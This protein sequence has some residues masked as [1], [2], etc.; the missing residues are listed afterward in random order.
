[1]TLAEENR[2]LREKIDK[3]EEVLDK[4]MEGPFFS[5]AISSKKHDEM[6]RVTLEDGKEVFL[7]VNPRLVPNTFEEGTKVLVNDTMILQLLPSA[8]EKSTPPV[9]FTFMNWDQIGGMKSQIQTIKE[10]VEMPILYAKYYK[11]FGLTPSKGILLYGPPGCGKTMIA[12]AIASAFLRGKD[13]TKDSFIYM[14]GGEMLSPYVGVAENNI[15]NVFK[16]ARKNYEENGHKSVIFIDEA[17]ALLP[18]RG[19]RKSS[20]VETTIV[21]TF[22]SEM[23]GFE[24]NSTFIILA[25]NH[26]TQLDPAIIR[27]GRIDLQ[28]AISRP[29]YEDAIDI[30]NI[31]LSKTKCSIASKTLATIAS[32]ALFKSNKVEEVSG[33]M[34][35]NIVDKA[36]LLAI[37]QS[38]ANKKIQG[39]TKENI[40]EVINNL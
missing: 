29:T 8:L 14:K 16:K 3:Y 22:L 40:N 26:P 17:E 28:V 4:L 39:I 10:T 38:I 18:A 32:D 12:K 23:D 2:E 6:Y 35:K 1:M 5:G 30:F 34:I 36:C 20:D 33:A 37:K 25:T 24:E 31:Y 9:N 27:P 11:E 21:P 13:I 15:K 19:S 7:K